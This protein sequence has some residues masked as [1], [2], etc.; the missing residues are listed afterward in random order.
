MGLSHLRFCPYYA[1]IFN[2]HDDV[3]DEDHPQHP[4]HDDAESDSDW[5]YS[6]W[7]NSSDANYTRLY[8]SDTPTSSYSPGEALTMGGGDMPPPPPPPSG[9]EINTTF[10]Q[11]KNIIITNHKHRTANPQM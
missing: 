6:N 3:G 9:H 5:S 4:D 10:K 7:S 1:T 11:T 2:E 8:I